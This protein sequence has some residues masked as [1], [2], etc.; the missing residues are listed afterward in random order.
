MSLSPKA[1]PGH[2]R[3]RRFIGTW[4]GPERQHGDDA[5]S[6]GHVRFQPDVEGL[7]MLQEY[8]QEQ[9][10]RIVFRGHG[11][12]AIEPESGDVLWWWFD[13]NDMP[14]LAPARGQ[15]D[16]DALVFERDTPQVSLRHRYQFDGDDHYLFSVEVKRPGEADFKPHL[17]ADY[18]HERLG[19][20][21]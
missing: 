7:V 8:R 15:W 10:G 4:T 13:S 9:A 14:P 17:D 3:L 11:V 1:G 5:A 6:I 19:L 2:Q 18:R 12:L 16:G 20:H 21:A